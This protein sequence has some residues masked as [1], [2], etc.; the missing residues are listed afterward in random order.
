MRYA[1]HLRTRI[2]KHTH[3]QKKEEIIGNRFP[4]I[5]RKID[6]HTNSLKKK[7]FFLFEYALVANA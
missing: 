6:M 2:L 1:D 4:P 3:M 5:D 7:F